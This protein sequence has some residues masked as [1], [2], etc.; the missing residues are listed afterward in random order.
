MTNEQK[1]KELSINVMADRHFESNGVCQRKQIENALMEMAEWKD[2]NFSIE[3]KQMI[4]KANQAVTQSFENGAIFIKKQEMIE[5]YK[6]DENSNQD[7]RLVKRS[8]LIRLVRNKMEQYE[9]QLSKQSDN[10]SCDDVDWM[11]LSS[12]MFSL[13]QTIQKSL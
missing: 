5:L 8:E 6:Q 4:E 1:A 10:I 7:S 13:L 11:G 9:S 3:R 12:D 2:K